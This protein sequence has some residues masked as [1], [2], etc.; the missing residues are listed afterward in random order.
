[1][2]TRLMTKTDDRVA[3]M[4]AAIEQKEYAAVPLAV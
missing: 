4:V 1:M 2:K 3:A